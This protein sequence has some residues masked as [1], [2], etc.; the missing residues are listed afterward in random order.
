VLGPIGMVHG[1]NDLPHRGAV[2]RRYLLVSQFAEQASVGGYPVNRNAARG[3]TFKEKPNVL[4]N[5]RFAS[6]EVEISHLHGGHCI[7]EFRQ[8]P[9][10]EFAGTRCAPVPARGAKVAEGAR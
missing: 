10:G 3:A 1:N 6:G 9:S 8:L 2:E 5:E 4:R 7:E